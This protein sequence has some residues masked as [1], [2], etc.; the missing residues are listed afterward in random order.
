MGKLLHNAGSRQLRHLSKC[1]IMCGRVC[2]KCRREIRMGMVT[3]YLSDHRHIYIWYYERFSV[4]IGKGGMVFHYEI[5]VISC[6]WGCLHH[7]LPNYS[8][9]SCVPARFNWSYLV[10]EDPSSQNF[11]SCWS[12]W[13]NACATLWLYIHADAWSHFTYNEVKPIPNKVY[14][15]LSYGQHCACRWPSN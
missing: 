11:V 10:K 13:W 15:I 14:L 2:S 6:Y 3:H 7:V 5:H 9:S 1:Y 8:L 4:F 12:Y